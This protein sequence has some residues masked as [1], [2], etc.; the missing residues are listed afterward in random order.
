MTDKTVAPAESTTKAVMT[1]PAEGRVDVDGLPDGEGSGHI[2]QDATRASIYARHSA[3]RRTELP[4]LSTLETP[5]NTES[6][7]VP[8][9]DASVESEEIEV[10]INGRTRKVL[11]SK[12]E[13]AG[14]VDAYQKKVAGSELLQQAAAERA[15]LREE[16]AAL[17]RTK[18]EVIFERNQLEV[19][20]KVAPKAAPAVDDEAL[21][22]M[23]REYHEAMI[24]GDMDKADDLLIRMQGARP[25]TPIDPDAIVERAVV[26]AKE[27]SA[28]EERQRR[29]VITERERL[30]AVAQ[31]EKDHADLA[32]DPTLRAI[33]NSKS[34]EIYRENPDKGPAAII[35]EATDHALDFVKRLKGPAV[36]ANPRLEAKRQ[37]TVIRGGSARAASMPAPKPQTKSSYV[38]QLRE[39]RGLP[40]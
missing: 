35:K 20:R 32:N 4:G 29:A 22:A 17:D 31:F 11:A 33:V 24:D 23:A 2:E 1:D 25:A 19:E 38:A 14:G 9:I 40:P 10:T 26:R 27:V 18:Q 5:T 7:E 34:A 6:A 16:Q 39:R 3:K 12:V 37:Q 36:P 15:R 13:D 30:E 28:E 8:I 21:K